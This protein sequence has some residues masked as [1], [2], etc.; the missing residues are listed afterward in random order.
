MDVSNGLIKVERALASVHRLAASNRYK[1]SLKQLSRISFRKERREIE[2]EASKSN[3]E[4]IKF[5]EPYKSYNPIWNNSQTTLND[6]YSL[7]NSLIT[8]FSEVSKIDLDINVKIDSCC[9]IDYTSI[10]HGYEP[11]EIPQVS[12]LQLSNVA[13]FDFPIV[14]I[15]KSYH[16][17]DSEEISSNVI[18]EILDI[19]SR[20]KNYLNGIINEANLLN[21]G[22][23]YNQR[24]LSMAIPLKECIISYLY[25]QFHTYDL[26]VQKMKNDFFEFLITYNEKERS[27]IFNTRL[28]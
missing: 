12:P 13:Q 22:S 4:P 15:S 1:K 20:I 3:Y 11:I 23:F 9:D 17:I 2:S 25:N 18:K 21:T 24:Y 16:L 19:L 26:K 27:K 14:E 10:L 7:R 28:I 5:S 8:D 6:L